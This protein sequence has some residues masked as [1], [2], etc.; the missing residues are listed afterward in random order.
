MEKD[1]SAVEK[2]INFQK[3]EW[4]IYRIAWVLMGLFLIA[5]LAGLWGSGPLSKRK[6]QVKNFTLE[7]E[8]FG[9]VQKSFKLFLHLNSNKTSPS[10]RINN[11]YFKS[12]QLVDIVP[13]PVLMK[14]IDK[15]LILEFGPAKNGTITFIIDPWKMGNHQLEITVDGRKEK[16]NQYIY[17]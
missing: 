9:R 15:D 11:D 17:F 8:R 16:V 12:M 1:I 14:V 6:V 4:V 3:K 10:V 13:R 5:G 7:Y 2:E